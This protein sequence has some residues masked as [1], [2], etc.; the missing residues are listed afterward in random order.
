MEKQR[1]SSNKKIL[2]YLLELPFAPSSQTAVQDFRKDK[3]NV[4]K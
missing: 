3:V 2:Q 4:F 1:Y